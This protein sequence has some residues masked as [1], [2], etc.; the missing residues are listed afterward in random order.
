MG[1]SSSY[2][3]PDLS[4]LNGYTIRINYNRLKSTT[5][6]GYF[7][8]YKK[9]LSIDWYQ[10]SSDEKH[11]HTTK[12]TFCTDDLFIAEG[13]TWINW[14]HKGKLSSIYIT[15]INDYSAHIVFD[16]YRCEIK[17]V[18]YPDI[19]VEVIEVANTIK[20]K[21]INCERH[22]KLN[23]NTEHKELNNK[24]S[25]LERYVVKL[26]KENTSLK[27]QLNDQQNEII[28]ENVD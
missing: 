24:I 17:R 8:E 4:C 15:P 11:F 19:F 7:H 16:G 2:Q 13:R 1:N 21:S 6:K 28:I 10:S 14:N 27:R 3:I 23:N 26:E 9:Y 12:F 20:H 18:T 5:K 22:M 25:E